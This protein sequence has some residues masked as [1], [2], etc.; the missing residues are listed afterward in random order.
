VLIL[1]A[2]VVVVVTLLGEGLTL[3]PLVQR[4]GLAQSE[5]Q[6]RREALARQRVTEAGLA[7][8]DEMAEAG[9]VDEDTANVYRQLFELR[10]DRVRS[11]LGDDEDAPDISGFRHELVLAQRRKL[12]ELYAKGKIS[13]DIRRTIS[14]T[15]DTQEPRTLEGDAG[16]GGGT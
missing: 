14:R 12:A 1:L 16:F 7:R 2:A 6:Q 10:L 11:V 5:L 4:L 3:G 13:D 15:L 8:L 9:E